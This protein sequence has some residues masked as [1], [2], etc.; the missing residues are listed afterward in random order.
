MDRQVNPT[1]EVLINDGICSEDNIKVC[2]D[3]VENYD[4]VITGG[5]NSGDKVLLN[6]ILNEIIKDRRI[7]VIQSSDYLYSFSDNNIIFMD[8]K[9]KDNISKDNT[10]ILITDCINEFNITELRNKGIK[11]IFTA[12][13]NNYDNCAEIVMK[14]FKVVKIKK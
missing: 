10:D 4:T 12:D 7:T 14:E 9:D 6:W 13:E 3:T 2:I 11:V 8:I 5:K 1:T